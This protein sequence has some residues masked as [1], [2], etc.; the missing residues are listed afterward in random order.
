MTVGILLCWNA[1][2]SNFAGVTVKYNDIMT[3]LYL[4]VAECVYVCMYTC[5]CMYV[6]FIHDVT[7]HDSFQHYPCS[8]LFTD[9]NCSGIEEPGFVFW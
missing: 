5:I 6:H 7:V 2:Y 8:Y 9:I 3:S 4:F 1:V